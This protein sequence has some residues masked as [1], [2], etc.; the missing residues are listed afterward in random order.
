MTE[1]GVPGR[2]APVSAVASA[3]L[4]AAA[5]ASGLVWAAA[6]RLGRPIP[7]PDF[8]LG[9][10]LPGISDDSVTWGTP[11][12]GYPIWHSAAMAAILIGLP[13][14]AALP[15]LARG[16]TRLVLL[17]AGALV[18]GSFAVLTVGR[19]GLLYAPAA[20]LLLIASTLASERRSEPAPSR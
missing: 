13:L 5:T 1:A 11:G 7:G 12:A 10:L 9:D 2:G 6:L 3:A 19:A 16:R 14:A 8:A 18:L 20:G 17:R 15:L 4:L